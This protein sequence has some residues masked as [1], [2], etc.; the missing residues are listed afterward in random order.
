MRPAQD[1]DS[2][3]LRLLL[4]ALSS[5][6]PVEKLAWVASAN[7]SPVAAATLARDDVS[8]TVEMR[9][10]AVAIRP[11]LETEPDSAA[12]PSSARVPLWMAAAGAVTC[13]AAVASLLPQAS[14]MAPAAGVAVCALFTAAMASSGLGFAALG[15]AFGSNAVNKQVVSPLPLAPVATDAAA[16][17][18]SVACGFEADVS[19][20]EGKAPMRAASSKGASLPPSLCRPGS[21]Q[22]ARAAAAIAA[23][24]GIQSPGAST[25]A[26]PGPG[27]A[28][29][30]PLRALTSVPSEAFWAAPETPA[31]TAPATELRSDVGP[32]SVMR[33]AIVPLAFLAAAA[34]GDVAAPEAGES[35]DVE[36]ALPRSSLPVGAGLGSS[37]ALAVAAASALLEC[38]A[39]LTGQGAAAAGEEV[40]EGSLRVPLR[41]VND[42]ALAA[43]TLFHGTPS[44]LDNTVACHG[45]LLRFT[46]VPLSIRPLEIPLGT[47]LDV[48]IVNTHVPK[49]TRTLVAA[50]RKLRDARPQVIEPIFASMTAIAT[51]AVDILSGSTARKMP[52][53]DVVGLPELVVAN[54]GLL[55]AL[56]VGHPA[57]DAVVAAARSA[58]LPAKLTGAGGGGCAFAVVPPGADESRVAAFVERC[59]TGDGGDLPRCTCVRTS[60]GKAGARLE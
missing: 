26:S 28:T 17:A 46:K 16:L 19:T 18:V 60:V 1:A 30:F 32:P 25:P 8:Y 35:W 51:A 38:R 11:F 4:P 21:G 33:Q 20:D 43:E 39:L 10:L 48:I 14:P 58:G 49:S 7:D 47:D 56:G 6:P 22:A 50:V 24:R 59:T 55:N 15:S 9:K 31:A 29:S 34:L 36:L 23:G 40:L 45:G 37:A 5:G 53:E 42:W 44:G 12:P 52:F 13:G 41:L 27:D 2:P 57:L 54:H 3:R